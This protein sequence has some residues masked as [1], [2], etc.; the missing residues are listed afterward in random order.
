MTQPLTVREAR[1]NRRAPLTQE[2]LAERS[3]VD[4][5]Y[6]SLIEA[7]KR[8]PSDDIKKRLAKALGVAPS[9]LRFPEPQPEATID[10]ALDREGHDHDA[11]VIAR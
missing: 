6:V 10:Q 9:R 7:G 8:V 2:Q 1:T 5:T 11:K 3:D 4:Q